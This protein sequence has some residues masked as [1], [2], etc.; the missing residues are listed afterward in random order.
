MKYRRG[1][2]KE[3]DDGIKRG[4]RVGEAAGRECAAYLLDHESFA[5]VPATSLVSVRHPRWKDCEKIGSLQSYVQHFCSA[6]DVGYSRF[7]A[8][9]VHRIAI[10]DMRLL[11]CD[12]HSGNVLVS[13][14]SSSNSTTSSGLRTATTTFKKECIPLSN[15]EPM[16]SLT[17]GPPS[18]RASLW[19]SDGSDEI[20]MITDTSTATSRASIASRSCSYEDYSPTNK[21]TRRR[22]HGVVKLIP[23]DHGF[24]LPRIDALSDASFEWL[25]WP[26]AR[27]PFTEDM[28]S[29]IQ[30]LDAD[31]DVRILR[32]YRTPRSSSCLRIENRSLLTLRV[33]TS[34]LKQCASIGM[35]PYEIGRTMCRS[36]MSPAEPSVLELLVAESS[37]IAKIDLSLRDVNNQEIFAFMS[38]FSKVSKGKIASCK[39][40]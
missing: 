9:D 32:R 24:T 29:Y 16:K 1:E 27:K 35:T 22:R 30:D 6:E 2:S 14:Q 38:A 31:A 37:R 11:N 8:S 34:W 20:P 15:S 10:L 17:P 21:N 4:I 26:Q 23:I 18:T 19:T 3:N 28:L 13:H 5:G 39:S 33:C 7:L 36:S 40:M 25:R 12:R